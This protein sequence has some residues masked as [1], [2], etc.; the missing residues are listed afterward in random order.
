MARV[1]VT[2]ASGLLG[3]HTLAAWPTS[4]EAVVPGRAEFDLL[5]PGAFA[6]LIREFRPDAVL[7]LAWS[8]SS[9]PGYRS[10]PANALWL[11]ASRDAARVC[12]DE[13]VRF[14]GTGSVV[15][16]RPDDEGLGDDA[17]SASKRSLRAELAGAIA[18][19]ELTWLRPHYVFDPDAASP[20]VLRE[21]RTARAEGRPVELS[22]PDAAH[23]FIHAS[24]VGRGVVASVVEGLAGVV[25]IGSGRVRTV[26]AL[27]SA[28]GASWTAGLESSSAPVDSAVA[29]TGTLRATGWSPYATEQFFAER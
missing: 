23:D 22:T 13:G 6:R 29:D 1:V 4:L 28:F 11:T 19:G 27:V 20:A 5:A 16:E 21:A 8:A 17:Y 10:S 26:G 3:R 14:F 2:G 15:D 18:A 7:H 25:D 9:T 12:L 24:D